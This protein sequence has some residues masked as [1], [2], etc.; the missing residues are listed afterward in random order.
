MEAS[1]SITSPSSEIE[2][3]ITISQLSPNC[4]LS[5]CVLFDRVS[6]LFYKGVDRNT[7]LGNSLPHMIIVV[8]VTA[9]DQSPPLC[10]AVESEM[11]ALGEV[12]ADSGGFDH[13]TNWWE[14]ETNPKE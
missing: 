2:T 14:K 13:V 12:V 8:A 11:H 1:Y 3:T 4:I 5:C 6:C 7:W 9:H 10:F